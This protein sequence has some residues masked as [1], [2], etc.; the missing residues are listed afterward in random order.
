M[1]FGSKENSF[2]M[3]KGFFIVTGSLWLLCS[4]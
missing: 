2:G 3:G 4:H 1:C